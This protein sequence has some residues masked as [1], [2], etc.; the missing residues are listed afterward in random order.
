MKIIET[1][2][3]YWN[4]HFYT[5]VYCMRLYENFNSIKELCDKMNINRKDFELHKTYKIR[6][7]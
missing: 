3:Y 1:D 4:I 6:R 2:K 5:D 7:Y